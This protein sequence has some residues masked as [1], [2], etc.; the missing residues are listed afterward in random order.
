MTERQQE[1]QARISYPNYRMSK[2]TDL[3]S[4]YGRCSAKKREAWE[5]CKNLCEKYNGEGLR[6][7]GRNAHRF[8]AGFEYTDS[9]TGD[10]MFMYIS[11]NYDQ[12]IRLY[13]CSRN[14]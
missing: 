5:Y 12:A 14:R 10:K 11:P 3:Y 8:S 13:E 6:V 2:Y 4:A 9:Q 7:I 1:R